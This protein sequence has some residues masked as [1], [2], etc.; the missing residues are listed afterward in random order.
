MPICERSVT[1]RL[2]S[3]RRSAHLW[4]VITVLFGQ[5]VVAQDDDSGRKYALL[6]GVRQYD[7]N[8]LRALPYAEQD[9]QEMAT[10][11]KQ[12][13]FRRVILLTQ[14]EGAT[15]SRSLPLAKNVRTSLKGLLEDRKKDDL[16]LIGFAGHGVQF[17]GEKDNYFCPMDADLSDRKSLISLAEVYDQLEK[18]N[19]GTKLLLVDACRNDPLAG[20]ARDGGG[21]DLSSATRPQIPDPPGGIAAM[22]S[23]SAGQ[24]AFEHEKLKHGIFFH[25]VIL[26][27][28]GAAKSRKRDEVTWDSLVE[29]VKDEVPDTVKDLLGDGVRQLP[30]NKG[31]LRGKATLVALTPSIRP[32]EPTTPPSSSP[33]SIT[34][35]PTALAWPFSAA[36]AKAAQE[37]LAKSLGKSVIEKNSLGMELVLIPPGKFTMGSPANEKD[38][39]KDEDQVEVTLTSPFWLGKT[40][41]TQGQWQKIMGTTP[42]KGENFVKEGPEFAATYVSWDDVQEFLKKLSQRDGVTYRLPTEAEWEWSCRAGT[43]SRFSFGDNDSDLG[44]YGWYGGLFGEG[45]AKTEHYAHEV[46]KKLANPFGLYDMHGNVFEW[47]EDV[48]IDKRPGGITP[49][50]ATGGEYRVLRGGSWSYEPHVARSAIRDW[51][52]PDYRVYSTGFRISRTQ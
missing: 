48:K 39:G 10:V 22:F 40:E 18:S 45:N 41:V 28:N 47:C 24:R 46:G 32:S 13:G 6:V 9:A 17:K 51:Y 50:V 14:S 7:P 44:R 8:Q 25:H 16:V 33:A 12:K 31:T 3:F 19:A 5:T 35:K 26:G 21:V 20:N 42:W 29:Y 11:L 43:S 15:E 27:L 38:R 36:Q 23:C 49:K 52:T 30:E 2:C 4:L 34:G 37:S 1:R